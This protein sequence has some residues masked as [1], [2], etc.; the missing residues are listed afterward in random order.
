MIQGTTQIDTGST[1]NGIVAQFPETIGVFNQF[2]IDSCCGGGIPLE[3]AARRDGAD[4]D[5]L[6]AALQKAI[7]LS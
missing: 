3:D 7:G 2:G 4:I 1:V 5:A 6:V